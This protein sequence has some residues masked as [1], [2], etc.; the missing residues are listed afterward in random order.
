MRLFVYEDI[1]GGGC[2]NQDVAGS[3]RTEALAMLCAILEDFSRLEF[4]LVG[5]QLE[6]VT[7]W[8]RS[9]GDHPF[10]H[11]ENVNVVEVD[12]PNEA[13]SQFITAVKNCDV[14]LIIA[15]ES[16]NRLRTLC[17]RVE[18]SGCESFNASQHAIELCGDKLAFA[19]HL[20]RHQ[21]PTIPTQSAVE[22]LPDAE[23]PGAEYP[24]AEYI[25]VKP[26]FG[27][28]SMGLN[29]I[30]LKELDSISVPDHSIVQP[31][32][33][34]EHCSIGCFYNSAVDT[35]VC[36]PVARQQLSTDG[37]FRYQG[38]SIPVLHVDWQ[39]VAEMVRRVVDSVEGL[40]GYFGID[41][42]VPDD[43]QPI[44]VEVNPRLTTSYV[45]YR[46]VTQ[47]NLVELFFT[48]QYLTKID[49][50]NHATFSP[51]GEIKTRPLTE[52]EVECCW[53]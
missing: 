23:Y 37:H 8:D 19:R 50:V 13:D 32:V 52:M 11:L 53:N 2:A 12:S 46:A 45:G 6:I 38:G 34:G 5:S 49:W 33:L 16:E 40:N 47:A 28:G 42:I 24:G 27:A 1:C 44:L 43:G 10:L 3:L 9:F 26:Q 51:S 20:Q 41:F 21:I 7:H 29:L 39:S 35:L 18:M 14:A 15:P 36:L 17:H 22:Q 4:A 25:V 30:H 48:Q 31:L